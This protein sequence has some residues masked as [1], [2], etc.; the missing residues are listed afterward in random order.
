M[1]DKNICW[2]YIRVQIIGFSVLLKKFNDIT[3]RRISVKF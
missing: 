2:A 3:I 1:Y